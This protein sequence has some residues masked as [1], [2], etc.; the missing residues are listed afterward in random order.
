MGS[1]C[2]SILHSLMAATTQ[3]YQCVHPHQAVEAYYRAKILMQEIDGILCRHVAMK[4]ANWHGQYQRSKRQ[5]PQTQQSQKQQL[6]IE[7][8]RPRG[9]HTQRTFHTYPPPNAIIPEPT[10]LAAMPL[11]RKESNNHMQTKH[12]LVPQ[13]HPTEPLTSTGIPVP[14]ILSAHTPL[15]NPWDRKNIARNQI[16]ASQNNSSRRVHVQKNDRGSSKLHRCTYCGKTF[17]HRWNFTTHVR[18]HT[19]ERPHKCDQCEWAFASLSNLN[20]HKKRKHQ[21]AKLGTGK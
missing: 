16:A 6:P 19:G 4:K 10:S 13:Y 1:P 15:T 12:M 2:D 7:N 9:F 20:R 14:P 11:P 17:D 5:E 8:Q 21:P 18:T 3:C